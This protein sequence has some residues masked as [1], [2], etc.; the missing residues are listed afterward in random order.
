MPSPFRTAFQDTLVFTQR[1]LTN[2]RQ[3]GAFVP[4][5]AAAARTIS[6][7][8]GPMQAGQVII[9]LGAG[10]GS[11]T[12]QLCADYPDQQVI[13]V[14]LDPTLAQRL[15]SNCPTAQVVE[16]CA[17]RLAE[18]LAARN[19]TP[20]A[21]GGV[22]SALP[23]VSLPPDLR[24]RIFKAIVDVLPTGRKYAQ[25]TYF[26]GAWK[27]FRLESWFNRA[28]DRRVWRN[29]PPAVIMTFARK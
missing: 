8:I 28:P 14:E 6:N 26:T 25:I 18:H 5:S 29:L 19:L 16:G 10:T 13:A 4:S 2:Y 12:R 22:V 23:F 7:A 20:A 17:S 11:F 27:N 3:I 9:E 15:R 21:V 1:F 24:E